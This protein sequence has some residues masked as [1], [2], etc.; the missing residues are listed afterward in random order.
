MRDAQLGQGDRRN[1]H[2][3]EVIGQ[4]LHLAVARIGYFPAGKHAEPR[5]T[6]ACAVGDLAERPGRDFELPAHELQRVH[7]LIVRQNSAICKRQDFSDDERQY[8]AVRVPENYRSVLG[9][10]LKTLLDAKGLRSDTLKAVYLD[11]PKAGKPVS[12]RSIRNILNG[13]GN[14]PG[15]DMLAAIASRL[16]LSVWQ[17][18]APNLSAAD[19]PRLALTADEKQMQKEFEQWRKRFNPPDRDG[20]QDGPAAHT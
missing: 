3:H 2:A 19:L 4:R 13:T 15:L 1:T 6:N 10:N 14:A 5:L 18:L 9:K 16:G 17:L 11:G 12:P 20:P 7:A 8:L